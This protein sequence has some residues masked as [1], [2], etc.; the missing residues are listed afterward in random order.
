MSSLTSCRQAVE[1]IAVWPSDPREVECRH[2]DP[3]RDPKV[4]QPHLDAVVHIAVISQLAE[5]RRNHVR[6]HPRRKPLFDQLPVFVKHAEGPTIALV[7]VLDRLR[8]WC[9]S[10]AEVGLE[11]RLIDGPQQPRRRERLA[12]SLA[13]W[14][15]TA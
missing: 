7:D 3:Q 1:R 11:I 13:W 5:E 6:R 15:W 9:V 12:V 10:I 14:R 4:H 8:A 2:H